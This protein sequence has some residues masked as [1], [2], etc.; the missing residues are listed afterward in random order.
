MVWAFEFLLK[1]TESQTFQWLSTSGSVGCYSKSKLNQPCL[2]NV[3]YRPLK[4]TSFVFVYEIKLHSQRNLSPKYATIHGMAA[5]TILS[6]RHQTD[7]ENNQQYYQHHNFYNTYFSL[8]FNC[9]HHFSCATAYYLYHQSIFCICVY[10]EKG[11]VSCVHNL[12]IR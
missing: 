11:F 9:L 8:L 12:Q 7:L 1:V 6:I 2:E 3:K 10:N 4:N 5:V